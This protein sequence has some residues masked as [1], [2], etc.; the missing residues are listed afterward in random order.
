MGL[1]TYQIGNNRSEKKKRFQVTFK[2]STNN[3]YNLG[4]ICSKDKM[5]HKKKHLNLTEQFYLF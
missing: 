1:N 5:K 2:Y 3:N 4:G